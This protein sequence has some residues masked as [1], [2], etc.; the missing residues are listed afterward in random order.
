[1][2]MLISS[3]Y[4]STLFIS[5]RVLFFSDYKY[6]CKFVYIFLKTL[7][8]LPRSIHDILSLHISVAS[9][10]SSPVTRLSNSDR[11]V[12]EPII[13]QYAVLFSF[14]LMKFPCFLFLCLA[15]GRLFRYSNSSDFSVACFVLC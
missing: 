15:F 2:C 9:R 14:F 6:K 12:G 8:F 10:Y 13:H 7:S 11:H 3:T 5:Q 4:L 1:M